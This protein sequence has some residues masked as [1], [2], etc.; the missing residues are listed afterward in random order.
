MGL[1]YLYLYCEL[2]FGSSSPYTGTDKTNNN[3]HKRNSKKTQ[4]KV[5]SRFSSVLLEMWEKKVFQLHQEDPFL[6]HLQF[7]ICQLSLHSVQVEIAQLV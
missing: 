1:L 2:S 7:I 4:Y 5:I 3:I 6:N